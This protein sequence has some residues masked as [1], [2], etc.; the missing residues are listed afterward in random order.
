VGPGQALHASHTAWV[1]VTVSQ[2][3]FVHT[4]RITIT[5]GGHPQVIAVPPNVRNYRWAGKVD[6]GDTDTWIGITADGD[7]PLPLPI[8]GSYQKDK[9]K[10]PG[11]TPFAIASPIL[12]DADGDGHWKRGDADLS[13]R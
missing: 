1:D 4:D 6:V 9:W 10:H 8:T 2:T 12:V 3:H 7:T 13:V 11:V 5:V